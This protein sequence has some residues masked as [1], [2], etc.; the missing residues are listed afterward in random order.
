MQKQVWDSKTLW[1]LVLATFTIVI[2][3]SAYPVG[4]F[5]AQTTI[6]KSYIYANGQHVATIDTAGTLT[7]SHSDYLGSARLAT[8]ES[9]EQIMKYD[10]APFGSTVTETGYSS[11]LSSY[12][13]TGKEQ[14]V[15]GL[16]YYGA[17]YYNPDIGRF[18]SVDPVYNPAESPYAYAA[19]NPVKFVDPSGLRI[20][21]P[22]DE[23]ERN[24]IVEDV[25][26]MVGEEAVRI[27]EEK[28]KYFLEATDKYKGKFPESFAIL[29]EIVEHEDIVIVSISEYKNPEYIV[30]KIREGTPT[31]IKLFGPLS[32][33]G[34]VF[35]EPKSEGVMRAMGGKKLYEWSKKSKSG[36]PEVY[37][38]LEKNVRGVEY[39]PYI[40]LSHE[41]GHALFYFKKDPRMGDPRTI[42][43]PNPVELDPNDPYS[44]GAGV[45]VEN[46]VRKEHG[47]DIQKSY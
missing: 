40:K 5:A 22:A 18:V 10:N 15:S 47:L 26:N 23:T 44:L 27:A 34:D 39:Q 25:T 43:N 38:S 16:Y 9:A 17:R 4:F 41:L 12:K 33:G 24:R 1:L 14:D 19:N 13:F 20:Q 6:G 31:E 11:A 32:G 28:G 21:L 36:L 37:Y 2:V 29:K 8:S 46:I 7:Y 45:Y 35:I 3:F 42:S 30:E